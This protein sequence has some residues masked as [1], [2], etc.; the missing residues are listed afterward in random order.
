MGSKP[1]RVV[2]W[3]TG[4]CGERALRE[5]ICD[6]RLELVGVLTYNPEKNGVDAGDLC[7]EPATGIKATTDRDAILALEADCVSYMP[8]ATGS[9]ITRAGLTIEQVLDDALS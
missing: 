2:Q 6:P 7:G 9:G 5:V 1:I 3:A 8:R 4:N